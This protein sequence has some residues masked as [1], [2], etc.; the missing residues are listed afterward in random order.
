MPFL[1]DLRQIMD[2]FKV[3]FASPKYQNVYEDI[4]ALFI[5][6]FVET[7]PPRLVNHACPKAGCGTCRDCRETSVNFAKMRTDRHGISGPRG[8]AE[9]ISQPKH[10]N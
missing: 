8:H 7:E 5:S 6:R 9:A 2:A 10:L 4:I 1:E 3:P